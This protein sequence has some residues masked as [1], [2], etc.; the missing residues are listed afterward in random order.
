LIVL[1]LFYF[2][3][4]FSNLNNGNFHFL[5]LQSFCRRL[6]WFGRK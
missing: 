2:V 6:I 3:S 4:I 5:K 1:I